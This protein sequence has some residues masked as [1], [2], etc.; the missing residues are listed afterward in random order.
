MEGRNGISEDWLS[1]WM[2]LFIFVLGL[3][4]FVGVDILGWGIKT[5][6][7]LDITKALNPISGDLKAMP[8]ITSLFL[9][10]IFLLV[11]TEIGAIAMGA[12]VGRFMIGFTLVFWI[13]YACWLTG[14]YA[15][16]AATDAG[17]MGI[18]WSL[19]LTGEAGFIVA[20]MVGLI[21]G[22]FFPRFAGVLQEATRP[23]LYIKTAIVIMGAGLGVK[24][25]G[26][27]GLASAV[28]FRGLCAI[29]EAYL[30]Y[31]A[32]VYFIARKYF[33]FSREW[34]APLASGISICGV[35]AAIATGGAIRARP[36][37]PIMVSSLVVIFAVVELLILPF[38]AQTFLWT[39]PMVA[40]AWMGLAV[41][42]DGAAVASGAIV[43]SLIR[44]KALVA[45]GISYKEGWMLMTATTVK[46]FIDIFIGVWAFILAVIWCAKIECTG[47][48]V[49]AMEIW[50]RFPKFVLGY[51]LTF[52]FMLFI[53]LAF[54]GVM[55]TAKAATA[56]MDVFRVLFFVLTFFTIGVVSNFKKLWEEGI[57]KLA[58]VYV[59]CLFGFI[60]WVGL[61]I[62][63]IFFHG[64]KP[65]LAG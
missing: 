10:Y 31:W 12:N 64:V 2:G 27:A 47:G 29:I 5:N 62:S 22:N 8:G 21:V 41:K 52:F 35:S 53:C 23:E 61:L 36:V 20:L 65:P 46:I 4:L 32:V 55:K 3:G 48:R 34:A 56:Q 49:R 44:A 43:D 15:Y 40:G 59:L 38:L 63:W 25:A 16:I 42:T 11:I 9:T 14:H 7:W 54:P 19:R 57:G 28:M 18:G 33:K 37:V 6:V 39:E 26:A 24:A 17:K 60:I 50:E 58:A 30:I 13:G 51:A 1:L 45:Q